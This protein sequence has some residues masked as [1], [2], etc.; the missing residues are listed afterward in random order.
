[1]TLVRDKCA[2]RD[3]LCAMAGRSIR[4]AREIRARLPVEGG[5]DSQSARIGQ[6]QLLLRYAGLRERGLS[7]PD[8]ADVE[9]RASSQNG[10][11]GIL[12]YLFG[13]LGMGGRRAVEICAGNGIECNAANFV[14][15]HGWTGLL[16]DAPPV[17]SPPLLVR[18][19]FGGGHA[20]RVA[21]TDRW[22]KAGGWAGPE[23]EGWRALANRAPSAASPA[24]SRR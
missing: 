22:A 1:M 10:D 2:T 4:R 5:P 19:A 3:Q 18:P 11:D 15:N 7:L 16:V 12:L 6:I 24:T 21:P 23:R 14:V 13:L 17:S 20:H 9:F 8:V